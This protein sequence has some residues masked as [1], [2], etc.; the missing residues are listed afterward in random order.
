M[1]TGDVENIQQMDIRDEMRNSYLTYAMSVIVSRALPDVRDGLKPS[2]RRILVAMNDLNLGPSSGR[3]KCQKISGDTSGNYHPHSGEGVY[4]T[5]VRLAQEWNMRQV[6]VDKQG[7]FGSLAGLPP[8]AARYTEARLSAAA[9]EM[10]D[11]IRRDTVDFVP[12]Y[13]Q[14]LTEP[15]VLPSRFP[16][17]L[18]NGSN[19]I[20]VGMRTMIPPHNLA[21]VCDAVQMLID[22]PDA[23][24]DDLMGCVQGPDFPTGGIICGQLGIRQA[25]KDGRSTIAVR[26]RTHF[27]QEKNHDVIVVTEIPYLQTRDGIREKLEQVVR[28]GRIKEISQIVDLT[29]RTIPAW[30]VRLHIILKRDA[31]REV[32]LNQLFRFSPLQTTL[33]LN[34]VALVGSRPKQ[35]SLKEIL[36]EFV[37][38]RVTV[39]RRRT[40]F[41]LAEA[42]KRKHTVEGLLIA[43]I[44]IDNVINTIRQSPDRKEACVRLQSL[45]VAGELIARALGDHGFQSFL[46]ERHPGMDTP[47][48]QENYGLTA[49]QADAIVAMQLGS[50]AG[51][52][53]E[54]LGEEHRKL[55]D[56]VDEFL[57]L[58]SDEAHL[59]AVV[60]DEMDQL[61][62][63]FGDGRRTEINDEEVGNVSKEE[64]ITEETMV[65]T[66]SHRGYIKRIKLDSYQAQHRGGKGIMGA[67]SDD[68][69]PIEHLFVASTHD[70]LMFF[71]DRGKVYWQKVYDLPLGSRIAKGRALVNLVRLEPDEKI[72]H[73]LAVRDFGGERQLVLATRNGIVKKTALSA[74]SRPLRGG[75]IAV[76]LDE[77]DE[78]I[79]VAIVGPGEDLLLASANGMAI[80]FAQEDARSMGRNTRGV[81]GISLR[82]GDYAV[83]MVVADPE[84]N[85]LTVCE[86]G[87]GKRTPIGV[88]DQD[89]PET[90]ES[91]SGKPET[92]SDIVD[93][94]VEDAS[95]ETEPASDETVR[96]G[97][98][99]RRQ[100][101]GGKGV[102]DIR[103]T[104][105]NGKVV[106]VTAISEEDEVLMITAGGKIQRVRVADIS[107]VG[108]NTQ[109]VRIIRMGEDD[110]LVSLARVPQEEIDEDAVAEEE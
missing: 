55:L 86:N 37:R 104:K 77:G 70:Y 106:A 35:L 42:K 68:E 56:D 96:S 28:E 80:R 25:F 43:Q 16:N 63:K 18:V 108:R 107:Q 29:D 100:K 44:N 20:A 72:F 45:E 48:A 1:S 36:E 27:E 64:L 4:L 39:L 105:R 66:L 110:R 19:G 32:V 93:E 84:L 62:A 49:K 6:L 54:K 24:L 109:G 14:R 94:A 13:D 98:K 8:A 67:K 83:G 21:E 51:L 52:E 26:A 92:D 7:N 40:E 88:V 12:T 57:R 87:F 82:E 99:Y 33:S 76:K 22:E 74:Y 2:Q 59:L 31:D 78:L 58:L 50:L 60:R 73:C 41:L 53:R 5:L 30:Q 89:E 71:T 101:R 85:L 81:K 79:G 97:M 46:S 3:V 38:H 23:T 15:V 95:G 75:L 47:V 10:L 17:L 102:I 69:D 65:V 91:E 34:F 11:D 9:T 90:E 61:K 103:T